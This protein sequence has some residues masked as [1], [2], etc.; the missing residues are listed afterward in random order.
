MHSGA[1]VAEWRWGGWLPGSWRIQDAAVLQWEEKGA[2]EGAVVVCIVEDAEARPKT[3]VEYI[4]CCQ[5]QDQRVS[6]VLRTHFL[7]LLP[8]THN[9]LA[10]LVHLHTYSAYMVTKHSELEV[11]DPFDW[12]CE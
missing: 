6:K 2:A 8:I 7:I 12:C 4:S 10:V 9:L 3:Q 1:V 11:V 5:L